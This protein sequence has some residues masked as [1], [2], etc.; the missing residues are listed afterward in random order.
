MT[1]EATSTKPKK[2]KRPLTSAEKRA[3]TR[4]KNVVKQRAGGGGK[5]ARTAL[6]KMEEI[7]ASLQLLSDVELRSLK[8][9]VD[10][11]LEFRKAQHRIFKSIYERT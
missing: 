5:A 11:Q 9:V 6:H 1:E 3:I 4:R 2:P 10:A 8:K 7:A